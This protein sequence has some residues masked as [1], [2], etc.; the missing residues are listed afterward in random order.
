[1]RGIMIGWESDGSLFQLPLQKVHYYTY[2]YNENSTPYPVTSVRRH[3]LYI[4][5]RFQLSSH[6]G[7]ADIFP[8]FQS[9]R[10]AVSKHRSYVSFEGETSLSLLPPLE[11]YDLSRV[12]TFDRAQSTFCIEPRNNASSHNCPKTMGADILFRAGEQPSVQL[13]RLSIYQVCLETCA[14]SQTR[15]VRSWRL[16]L[17]RVPR[18]NVGA[19]VNAP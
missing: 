9:C 16:D 8:T 4:Y 17:E 1:M 11:L 12:I 18:Q 2:I 10:F 7:S 15:I 14:R 19:R 5:T 13:S 3:E 6:V